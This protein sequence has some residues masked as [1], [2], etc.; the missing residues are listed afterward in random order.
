[1]ERLTISLPAEQRQFLKDA[2]ARGEYA[3]E[4]EVLRDLIRRRQERRAAAIRSIDA[5]LRKGLEGESVPL[6]K[7][8]MA[9]MWQEA[10]S[11]V[12]AKRSA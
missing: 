8:E 6:T 4:S 1:M 11:G 9:R 7:E 3:S 12:K 5:E 10:R 2:V